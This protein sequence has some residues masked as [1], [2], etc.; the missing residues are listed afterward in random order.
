MFII[1]FLGFNFFLI[2]EPFI[3][4]LSFVEFKED[5]LIIK[6]PSSLIKN[7]VEK[8]YQTLIADAA[9]KVGGS[10]FKIQIHIDSNDTPIANFI[11]LMMV[12]Q[13][14]YRE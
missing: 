3:S 2:F 13:W 5:S 8:K 14:V 6:A 1:F 4:P 9:E 10:K 11:L 7:H 12:E